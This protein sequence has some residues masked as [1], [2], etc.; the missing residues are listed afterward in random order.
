MLSAT[1]ATVTLLA[2]L[3]MATCHALSKYCVRLLRRASSPRQCG[4]AGVPLVLLASRGYQLAE[5]LMAHSTMYAMHQYKPS[6]ISVTTRI[7][8]LP[9]PDGF[10][11]SLCRTRPREPSSVLAFLAHVVADR[12]YAPHQAEGAI[13][14]SSA[15]PPAPVPY[16]A[17]EQVG[18]WS[19]GML[20]PR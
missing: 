4:A 19:A 16:G 5:A 2:G 15:S 7:L 8:W 13:Q 20:S 18:P 17:Q 3:Q 10:P 11:G 14:C 12:D 1:S 6:I 9:G